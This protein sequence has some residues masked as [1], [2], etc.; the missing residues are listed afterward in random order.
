MEH[1]DRLIKETSRRLFYVSTAGYVYSI[2]KM[3][4]K[5]RYCRYK[6]QM[7]N[8]IVRVGLHGLKTSNL[9]KLVW[10]GQTGQYLGKDWNILPKDGNEENCAFENL[11]PVRKEEVSR[12]TG[13]M[14]RSRAVVVRRGGN[15]EIEWFRSAREAAK[16]LYCSYQTL[17]DYLNG[18]TRHSVLARQGR[19]M[20]WADEYETKGKRAYENREHED[21]IQEQPVLGDR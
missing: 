7:H 17:L 4:Q 21:H 9:K 10:W 1:F 11:R 13:P 5:G 16:S 6:N 18:K 3:S 2:G 19:L 15:A 12:V 14:S 20:M 8:G